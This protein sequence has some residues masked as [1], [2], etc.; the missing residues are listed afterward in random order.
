M[1]RLRR[2]LTWAALGLVAVLIAIQLVPYGRDHANPAG[3]REIAWDS[4]RTQQVM[5]DAC[6]DCHSNLTKWPWYSNVAPVSWLVQKDVD[7]GRHK[8]N[9]STDEPEVEKMIEAIGEGSM[10]PWRYKP[11]HP[12]ARLSEAEKRDL[13]RGLQATFAG[14]DDG[15]RGH[16]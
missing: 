11:A 2:I 14:G 9:L 1:R 16:D 8:L 15:R 6:M 3:G 12:G 10:P 5:A 13:I 4:P 7:D